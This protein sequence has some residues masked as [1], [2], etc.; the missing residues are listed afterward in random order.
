MAKPTESMVAELASWNN[1]DGIDLETWV[2]CSGNFKLAV[3]YATIFWPLFVRFEDYVL[4]DGFSEKS[5]RGF[6]VQCKGDKRAVETV[7]NHVHIADLQYAGCEDIS[8]DKVVFIGN[9]MKK[10]WEA[11][12]KW[13]FPDR[14]CNVSFHEPEDRKDL[15]AF[16]LSFWQKKH[17]EKN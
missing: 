10:I 3:G 15:V 6:E 13:Q 17:E 12:L 8:E 7:M 5:L 1:G 2:G 9:V 4:R 14:P 16:E 11:K